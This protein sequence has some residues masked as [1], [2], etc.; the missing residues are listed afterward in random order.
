MMAWP[1]LLSINARKDARKDASKGAKKDTKKD[2]RILA[3][4]LCFDTKSIGKE[5][6]SV[7]HTT[8]RAFLNL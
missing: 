8:V 4:G 2:A 7:V 5:A 1:G 3:S 6:P